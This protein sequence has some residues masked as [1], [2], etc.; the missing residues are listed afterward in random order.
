MKYTTQIL[1]IFILFF[2]PLTTSACSFIF[3]EPQETYDESE[4]VFI[5]QITNLEWDGEL[6]GQREVT[7]N[8]SKTYKGSV[9]S[10]VTLTT[11]ANSAM[12]GYDEGSLSEG[13]I[14][15]I[16]TNSSGSFNSHPN[17]K[18]FNSIEEA[19]SYTDKLSGEEEPV[20]CTLEYAPVC[21][22]IDTGIRC[23]T[24]P[25]DTYVEKTYSNMCMLEGAKAEF[26]HEGECK[27][28][29]NSVP[30]RPVINN[31]VIEEPEENN[32]VIVVEEKP[33]E[34]DSFIKR[35]WNIILMLFGF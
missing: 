30:E 4:T 32:N 33:K 20:F 19:R 29:V 5:G 10:S 12:C 1:F 13:D 17:N 22:Q 26:L 27:T 9:A 21:G 7:F 14:W 23:V 8:V 16:N 18:K 34:K 6:N 15:L 31:P 2:I 25:C 3:S 28:T 24:T 35:F 11:G